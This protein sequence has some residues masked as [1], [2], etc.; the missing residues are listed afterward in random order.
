VGSRPGGFLMETLELF[1]RRIPRRPYATDELGPGLQ[2]MS[3][4]RA[5]KRR[6]LQINPPSVRFWLAFDIDD[7]S[8][9]V[10]WDGA[11]L[12]EPAWTAQNPANGHAHSVWGI[13][14]PV[15]L[16]KPDRQKPVRYLAAVESAYR[17]AL[18]ADPAY[19]GLLTKN[20]LSPHWR[21]FWGRFG[22][23]GLDELAEYVDLDRHKPRRSIDAEQIGLGRNVALFDWLRL[24]AYRSWRRYKLIGATGAD[25]ADAC[26]TAARERNGEFRTPLHDPEVV[27]VAKSVSGWV[28]QRFTLAEFE[29]I[30]RKRGQSSGAKRKS[31]SQERRERWMPSILEMLDQGHSQQVVADTVGVSRMTINNWLKAVK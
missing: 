30:Q 2:R 8:G 14:A 13:E 6:H 21:T 25:F 29:R 22:I 5:L 9:A 10:A 23:Y 20:P 11:N 19:G 18:G 28:W 12:P 1:E 15:L 17:A 16:D 3:P 7:Q 27:Q 31:A 26:R 24:W 4:E